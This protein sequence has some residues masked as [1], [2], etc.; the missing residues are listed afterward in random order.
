[1]P[2]E[3]DFDQYTFNVTESDKII[4]PIKFLD[5]AFEWLYSC[6]DLVSVA[7]MRFS[8]GNRF[9]DRYKAFILSKI[10]EIHP[11]DDNFQYNTIKSL[12]EKEN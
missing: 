3:I 8:H 4:V 9:A 10:T 11:Y 7:E 1:M 5:F 2:D 12:L 6:D